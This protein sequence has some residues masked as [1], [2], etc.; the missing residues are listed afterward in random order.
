MIQTFPQTAPVHQ[1][2]KGYRSLLNKVKKTKQPLFLLKNNYPESVL[3][4]F[5]YWEDW[6][7]V[8][9]QLEEEDLQDSIDSAEEAIKN[10]QIKELKSLKDLIE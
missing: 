4:D 9:H 5:S 8:I 10:G 1:L 6:T 7:K 3:L 2:Q